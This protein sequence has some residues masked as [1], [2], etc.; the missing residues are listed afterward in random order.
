MTGK[1]Q[2]ELFVCSLSIAA[3][4]EENSKFA[5]GSRTRPSQTC[6]R[7]V[8]FV[9][10]ST[11]VVEDFFSALFL[12]KCIQTFRKP[13]NGRPL[14]PDRTDKSA[15]SS[16]QPAGRPPRRRR[17]TAARHRLDSAG[18]WLKRYVRCV[19]CCCGVLEAS[20]RSEPESRA[21]SGARHWQLG[22][23]LGV[24]VTGP[25]RT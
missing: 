16:L 25:G 17:R 20:P 7:S 3:L 24:R 14:G 15:K 2:Q 19:P 1:S 5:A 13:T 4:H 9:V 8:N 22:V 18:W 21:E 10:A 12:N 11:A 23:R 6:S